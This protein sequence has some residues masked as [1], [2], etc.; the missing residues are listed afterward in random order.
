MAAFHRGIPVGHV[1]AG[2]R[3][4]DRLSPFP[5]E[6]NRR[7]ITQLATLHFAATPGNRDVLLRE[8]VP[9]A[10]VFVTG[11]PVVDALEAILQ[12]VSGSTAVN[13]ILAATDGLKRIVL[14]TH[15]R[16]SFGGYMATSLEVLRRFVETH[17][18][19]ALL[20]PVH[21]NPVVVETTKRVLGQHPRIHLIAPLNYEEFVLLLSRAWLIVSDSG[22]VQEEA[23]TL[24]KPLIILR[25]NTERPEAVQCGIARLVGSRPERLA[26]LLEEA[27][28]PRSW[29]H[30]T[31]KIRNPF[32]NGD[33]G[34][35]IV[36]VITS[37][38]FDPTPA[39]STAH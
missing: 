6:M 25:E 19:V 11:N 1:E 33:A 20:F 10:A 17:D 18:D 34:V 12:K 5:E 37:H 38:L 35:R 7:V 27:A 24:G 36:D 14:T 9:D 39:M 4:G 29:A 23:P 31:E 3:S 21:P 30:E 15:R 26:S 22:G 32:G 2:L 8:G 16:E 13:S 28:H